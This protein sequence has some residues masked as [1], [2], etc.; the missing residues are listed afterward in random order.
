LCFS[1]FVVVAVVFVAFGV[2][3]VEV[4]SVFFVLVAEV[5]AFVVEVVSFV[6]GIVAFVVGVV[7]GASVVW[8]FLCGGFG[9]DLDG[10]GGHG[11]SGHLCGRSKHIVCDSTTGQRGV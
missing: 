2:V 4:V 8:K 3:E 5:V 11:E 1:A 10:G 6:V 9:V 7:V